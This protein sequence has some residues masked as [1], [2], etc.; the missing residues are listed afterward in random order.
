[1]RRLYF[2]LPDVD[3]ARAVVEDLL[4]KRVEERHIHLLARRGTPLEDLPQAT[5]AQRTDLVPALERGVTIG[6]S[7]KS[8]KK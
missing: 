2:L 7:A 4:L 6:G 1:M 8:D 3:R 5:I